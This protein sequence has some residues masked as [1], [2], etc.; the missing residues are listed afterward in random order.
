MTQRTARGASRGHV[1]TTHELLLAAAIAGTLS[2]VPSTL[3][4]LFTGRNPLDTIRAAATLV[5]GSDARSTTRQVVTG[6]AVHGMLTL[7]WTAVLAGVLPRRH[8]VAWGAVG[9]LGIAAL[10]LGLVGPRYP[11]IAALPVG[12]QIAD[13]LA[14]GALVGLVLSRPADEQRR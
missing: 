9:G 13:H 12:G 2:G 1:H 11:A 5:P 7:G 10:D 6:L 14:F 8:A 4:A 3:Y